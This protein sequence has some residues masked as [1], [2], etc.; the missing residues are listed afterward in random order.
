M[1]QSLIHFSSTFVCV[2]RGPFIQSMINFRRRERQAQADKVDPK[3]FPQ[4]HWR[5]KVKWRKNTR[6]SLHTQ[7]WNYAEHM[8]SSASCVA[9]WTVELDKANHPQGQIAPL[10]KTLVSDA[11][12]IRTAQWSVSP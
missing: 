2:A 6:D 9:S 12:T 5:A 4:M 7:L 1:G 11:A 10:T 8:M 3:K